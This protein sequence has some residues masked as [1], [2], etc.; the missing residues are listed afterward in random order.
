MEINTNIPQIIQPLYDCLVN[1]EADL[2]F[3]GSQ[4][5][6]D[7]PVYKELDEGVLVAQTMV[8]SKNH[9]VLLFRVSQQTDEA[10]FDTKYKE[11]IVLK[12]NKKL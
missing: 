4:M 8:L 3:A 6:F 12:L 5:F 1:H 10:S 7:F 2:A 9:G 11:E